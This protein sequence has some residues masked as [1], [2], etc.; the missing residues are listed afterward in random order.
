MGLI[1]DLMQGFGKEVSKV[2]VRSQELMKLIIFLK[3]LENWIEKR[4]PNL[5]K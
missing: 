2:Q 1:D 3:K 4:R 5:L